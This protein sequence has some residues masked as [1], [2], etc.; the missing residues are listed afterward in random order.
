MNTLQQLNEEMLKLMKKTSGVLGA[1]EFGS[2]MHHTRDQYSDIDIVFLV[3]E[4]SYNEIDQQ[5]PDIL[6]T[7]C[8]HLLILWPE[9]FNGPSMKNYNCILERDGQ[10]LQYDIFL[11]NDAALDDEMCKIH[12]ADLQTENI[13]FDRTGKV[14]A[15]INADRIRQTWSDDIFRLIDTYWLHI[16]MTN[17]YFLRQDYFK[18]EGVLRILMDTH[19]SLLL[20]AY[21]R[22]TW[23]GTANK[24]HYLPAEKQNH[25]KH[26]Y[27]DKD[28]HKT[29][30]NLHQSMLWFTEDILELDMAEATHQNRKISEIIQKTWEETINT[31]TLN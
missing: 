3:E 26:Y 17:K 28:F 6:E 22:I 18:L 10:I 7:I 12:Y 13:Y 9:D 5:L 2:G 15:L 1:W 23:G 25:L 16:H 30:E 31:P 21:D 29:A 11:L 14:A 8:D 20:T 4:A 27:C 24:L 19:S